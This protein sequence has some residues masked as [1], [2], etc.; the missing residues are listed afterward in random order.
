MN[1]VSRRRK[2]SWHQDNTA[3]ELFKALA[4]YCEAHDAEA[5]YYGQGEF[6]QNF[7][8]EV[9]NLLGKEAAVFMPSGV[10]AQQIA[11]RIW[12]DSAHCQNI[13]FHPS[14]HFEVNEHRGY[15]QM[16]GLQGMPL[17]GKN[18]PII[19]QDLD[20][21]PEPLAVL[22]VELP[23]RNLG[24][25]VPSWE[26][27][28]KLY[29]RAQ[30]R[31]I[32]MHL[33]GA[34]LWEAGPAYDRPYAEICKLFDSVYVSFYKGL[35]GMAGAMLTGAND[36]ISQARIWQRRFGGNLITMHPYV[37]SA[38]MG[39]DTR[40]GKM[41]DYRERAISLAAALS[42]LSGI[43]VKPSPPHTNMFQIF[44]NT[45]SEILRKAQER[46]A[47]EDGIVLCRAV[48][49]ADVPKWSYTEIVVG[50]N[51]LEMTNE[52][53]VPLYKKLIELSQQLR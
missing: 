45:S 47:T 16:L 3:A 17:G 19:A 31:G 18:A 51:A 29:E 39:F 8:Q 1:Q 15:S 21:C 44:L 41:A 24:G 36:F 27:L 11:L 26:E 20:G 52:E 46:V 34:R 14:T 9:A 13:A 25:I 22:L 42:E 33:D 30:A 10:M 23:L 2:V 7:E 5:E 40:L 43:V 28:L 12:S 53:L 35:G 49:D 4:Q 38:K 50:D 6:L 37:V 48:F 32:R